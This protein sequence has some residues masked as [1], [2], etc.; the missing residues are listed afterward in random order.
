VLDIE[1]KITVTIAEN[2]LKEIIA[3]YLTEHGSFKFDPKNVTL[4]VGTKLV[5]YGMAEHQ[6]TYFKECTAVTKGVLK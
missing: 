6:V 3:E 2:E 5:G 4:H 1:N